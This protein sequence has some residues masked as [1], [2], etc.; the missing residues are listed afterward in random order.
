M[1]NEIKD[2]YEN[3]HNLKEPFDTIY[4]VTKTL[5]EGCSA[6]VK[7]CIRNSDGK[8]FA[9]KIVNYFGD[10]EKLHLVFHQQLKSS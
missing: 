10:D 6:I 9:V 1:F 3:I 7:S 4:T 5:G 2:D 8:E